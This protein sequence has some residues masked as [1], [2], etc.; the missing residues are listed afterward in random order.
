MIGDKDLD[1]VRETHSTQWLVDLVA[2]AA[3]KFGYSQY[4]FQQD[5]DVEDDHLAFVERGIPSIDIIDLDYG[6]NNSYHHTAQD[7]MDKISAHSLTIDGDVFME[8]I[9]LIDQRQ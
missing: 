6:P 4:F 9:R 2:Q 1:I 5:L 3:K 7:T 8:T